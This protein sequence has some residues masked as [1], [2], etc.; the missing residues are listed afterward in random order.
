M[1]RV[2]IKASG[3]VI[4][5]KQFEKEIHEEAE[6]YCV[7]LIHG[8][9]EQFNKASE[10]EIHFE[11][12]IRIASQ[13]QLEKFYHGPQQQIRDYLTSVFGD[14]VL[15]ISPI[16][17]KDGQFENTNSDDIFIELYELKLD[18]LRCFEKGIVYTSPGTNKSHLQFPGVE[19]KYI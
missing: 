5:N 12:G 15:I 16:T 6:R 13:E 7:V 19:I 9:G 17:I 14:K 18:E 11:N 2:L 8:A 3:G 10:E 4:G 1:E